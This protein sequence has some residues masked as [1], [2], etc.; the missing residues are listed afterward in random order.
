MTD[1]SDNSLPVLDEIAVNYGSLVSII[2][3]RMITDREIAKEAAQQVWVEITRS[4]PSF[5]GRS[6]ISTWIYTITRRVA[7]NYVTNEKHYSVSALSKYMD[8]VKIEP[9]VNS[10]PEYVLWV[11]EMCNRCLTGILYCLDNESRLAYVFREIANL[12]YSDISGIF[13]RDEQTVRKS[14]SRSRRKVQS[15]LKG[16]CMYHSG[17]GKCQCRMKKWIKQINFDKEYLKIRD[18]KHRI[19]AYKESTKVLPKLNY[20]NNIL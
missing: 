8:G 1:R 7:M 19:N 4:Y 6:K 12:P 20:W 18:I 14:V 10:G 3:R 11:K 15:F 16:R 13:D 9:P 2:C 17:N 5:K